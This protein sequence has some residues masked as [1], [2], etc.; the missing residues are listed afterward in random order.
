MP[1]VI[2][3]TAKDRDRGLQNGRGTGSTARDVGGAVLQ[4]LLL[5]QHLPSPHQ[6]PGQFQCHA[7]GLDGVNA[8]PGNTPCSSVCHPTEN[9]HN[10]FMHPTLNT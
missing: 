10:N 2:G 8:P 3:L 1:R 9:C 7:W 6:Q 4:D 5:S